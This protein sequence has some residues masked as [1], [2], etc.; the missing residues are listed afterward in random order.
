M[1]RIAFVG[2]VGAGKTTLFN[3]LRGNYS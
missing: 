3:A 2:A 1:K